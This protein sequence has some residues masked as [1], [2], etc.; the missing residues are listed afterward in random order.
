MKYHEFLRL[1]PRVVTT[2]DNGFARG[3]ADRN[4]E[5]TK[6]KPRDETYGRNHTVNNEV[7]LSGRNASWPV[8]CL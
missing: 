4:H 2:I 3:R 5:T 8:A 1:Q 7:K 6:P